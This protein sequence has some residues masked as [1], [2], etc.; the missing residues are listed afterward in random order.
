[1]LRYGDFRFFKMADVAIFDFQILK[2]LTVGTLK[3]A[4]LLHP[5]K[6]CRNRLELRE[7]KKLRETDSSFVL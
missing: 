4:K 3:M 2:I 6:F 5:A 1:M 7:T